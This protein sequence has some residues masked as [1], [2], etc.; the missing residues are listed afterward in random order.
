MLPVGS[1]AV[2]PPFP[3]VIGGAGVETFTGWT[4]YG[5]SRNQLFGWGVGK[6]VRAERFLGKGQVARGVGEFLE[7][8]IGNFEFIDPETSTFGTDLSSQFG[9]FSANPST[10]S[11]GF[12]IK[13]RF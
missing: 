2:G 9:E 12:S 13:T 8:G 10:R 4:K 6:D 5:C 3:D 11:L 7:L 1:L